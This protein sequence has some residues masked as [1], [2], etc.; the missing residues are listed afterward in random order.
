MQGLSFAGLYR[1][2]R[3]SHRMKSAMSAF[4]PKRAS[5]TPFR[6]R[7]EPIRWSVLS[8]GGG[9]EWARKSRW[10]RG[11]NTASRDVEAPPCAKDGTSSQLGMSAFGP[12]RTYRFAPHI[13]KRTSDLIRT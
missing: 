6:G 10:Q 2:R 3:L 4:G 11:K 13:S 9:N 7:F 5:A 12:K 1:Q 8:F